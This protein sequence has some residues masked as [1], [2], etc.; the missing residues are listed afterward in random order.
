M[1]SA[2]G[3]LLDEA[4]V[5]EFLASNRDFLT[6]HPDLLS[7][8]DVRHGIDGAVSL[9]ERQIAILRNR[10]TE[11]SKRLNTAL[12]NARDNDRTFTQT[13][14]FTLALMDTTD[15][16]DIDAVLAHHLVAGFDADHAVC[17]VRGWTPEAPL[18]HLAGCEADAEPPLAR[19]F[20]HLEP[21]CAVYR[22]EEYARLF[23]G[24]ALAGPGSVALVPVRSSTEDAA[25]G[26][27]AT[28]AI[29]AADP[30][31]FAPDM[32]DI[33]LRYIGDALARTLTRLRIGSAG[34][35]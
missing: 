23:P 2:A 18:A 5:A 22:P 9:L 21:D 7:H 27:N 6:R 13:R 35:Q 16:A 8:L 19:L 30:T 1:T 11:L 12:A 32:G 14:A 25:A 17:Y 31:Y 28:L 15:A 33:F 24:A 26:L 29:G 34:G 20:D 10:N 3:Q 4:A